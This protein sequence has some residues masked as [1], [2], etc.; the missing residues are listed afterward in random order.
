M[1]K[2]LILLTFSLIVLNFYSSNSIANECEGSPWSKTI[3]DNKDKHFEFPF[4][5][6]R[7]DVGIF[8]D[9]KWDQ[10]LKKIIIKRDKNKYPIVRFSLFN[11]VEIEQGSIIKSL[12]NN[13]L[14]RLSDAKIKAIFSENLNS[15]LY[16][17][18]LNNGKKITIE[19]KPYKLNNFKL[20]DFELKSIQNINS[21]KGIIEISFNSLFENSRPDLLNTLVKNDFIDDEGNYEAVCEPVREYI[22]FPIFQFSNTTIGDKLSNSRH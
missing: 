13:D 5:E 10:D 20:V 2:R 1:F 15:G 8:F 6:E 11:K 18:E 16:Y 3:L 9:F 14:S 21:K 4:L 17:I 12:E 22:N 19:A 7:N